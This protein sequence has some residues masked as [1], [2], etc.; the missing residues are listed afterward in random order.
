MDLSKNSDVSDLFANF[1]R[2]SSKLK[3]N[4][5]GRD[6]SLVLLMFTKPPFEPLHRPS[7]TLPTIP[8]AEATKEDT[9]PRFAV[10]NRE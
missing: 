6:L 4:V 5:I 7:E 10:V 1:A 9:K 2:D 3:T 8:A